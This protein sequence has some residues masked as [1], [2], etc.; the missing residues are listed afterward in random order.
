MTISRSSHKLVTTNMSLIQR[1]VR[2]L[3]PVG[4]ATPGIDEWNVTSASIQKLVLTCPSC[5][6]SLANHQFA[7][8]GQRV[9][10]RE[11]SPDGDSFLNAV[12]EHNWTRV[13]EWQ[14]W[15]PAKD[16]ESCDF[17]RCPLGCDV[18]LVSIWRA[19]LFDENSLVHYEALER[20]HSVDK[21]LGSPWRLLAI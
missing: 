12:R 11:F 16:V 10:D 14:E 4:G 7:S 15:N 2:W 13:K 6:G 18:V 9:L 3:L 21:Y 17:L 5:S 19:E 8:L 20:G 1:L